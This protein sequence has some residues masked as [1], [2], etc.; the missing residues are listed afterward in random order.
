MIR[1]IFGFIFS[2]LFWIC[3]FVGFIILTFS[4]VLFY[5]QK[6][7]FSS[8][9]KSLKQDSVLS[10]T[11]NGKYIEHV[12]SSGIESL[13]IGKEGSLYDLT[14]AVNKAAQ[15][16]KIKGMVV[17]I[18][19]PKLGTGQLQ[20]L[21]DAL[22]NFRKSGKPSWCYADTF[23]ESSSGTGVYYLATACD[24]IWLQPLGSVNLVGISLETMFAKSA[25]EK[26]DVK[27]ELAQRK[28]YKS[29]IE[30]LTRDDFSD[31][32]REEQQAIADSILGQIVDG[33]AKERKF[34]HDHVRF[35]ISNGPYLTQ[36]A[37]NEKLVDRLG[38]RQE[39]TPAIKEVLGQHI[40]FTT[41]STYLQ[42]LHHEN[43]EN[44]IALIFGSGLIQGDGGHSALQELILSANTTYKAFQLAIEDP[45]VKAIVFRVNSGGGSPTA[46]ETIYSIINYAKEHAKKPV[47]IS[48]SDAAAS[49]G[50]WISVAGSKIV[51]QPATLTGSIGVFGGKYVLSGLLEKIGIKLGEISTS[52]NASMWSVNESFTPS[53]W[54]KLNALMDNVYDNFTSR[55][56][57]GRK[58]TPEQVEKVARGRVWTGEQAL[59]LGLVDQLGGI[60]TAIELAKKE[61]G[62][63]DASIEIYPKHKT[64]FENLA[65][66]FAHEEEET[67][68]EAGILGTYLMPFRKVFAAFTVLLSSQEIL[69]T[70][71]VEVK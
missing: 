37:L 51:A 47:I 35:L 29:F 59:A 1:A 2:F 39:L 54:V 24:Q 7:P 17:R 22:L 60:S 44:K 15:D 64:L 16:N 3:A 33:I 31:P 30:S 69:Y 63:S 5:S 43:K 18:E 27:P 36:D 8:P 49:G 26:L 45:G 23:G 19:S 25:L 53:Q 71:L 40:S 38:F 12:D 58:M 57:R 68:N 34:A 9:I 42:T 6:G 62:L 20:E 50:Y 67:V 55:V 52:E 46:S 13:F 11:L 21:R 66:L 4:L 14:R 41:P 48:M 32:N 56:A 61:A 28:E 65:S 70:P 10:I